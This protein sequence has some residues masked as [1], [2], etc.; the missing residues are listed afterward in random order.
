[1]NL[2]NVS[3][4][5]NIYANWILALQEFWGFLNTN[6]NY[7]LEPLAVSFMPFQVVYVLFKLTGIGSYTFLEFILGGGLLIYVGY[8]F[9]S[10]LLDLLS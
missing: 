8:Q 3:S 6:I 5:V 7:F 1:M 4:L 9:I 2:I 10:W